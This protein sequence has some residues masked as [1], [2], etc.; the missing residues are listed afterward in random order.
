MMPELVAEYDRNPVGS[1]VTIRCW[2]WAMGGRFVLLGDAAHAIVPF[3]GQ[4]ANASFE[5]C[6]ALVDALERHPG[7]VARAIDEYQRERKPN[8][9]AI[10]DMALDN[11]VEM[12]DRTAQ[13][14][15]KLKK[16]LDHALNRLM[17]RAFV[18]LYD[19]VSFT[20]VPYAAARARARRQDRV[21]L[22]AAIAVA[23]LLVVGAG[24]AAG[25]LK[26]GAG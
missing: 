22:D 8:A 25:W 6:E 16:K 26:G 12:R 7:D 4:G 20:T 11:F 3:Y 17:P 13:L 9:D 2:P 5:D 19:L 10:A 24:V 15:F 23:A 18:P 21:V 14:G 1:L